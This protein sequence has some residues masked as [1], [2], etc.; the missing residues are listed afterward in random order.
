MAAMTRLP[1]GGE[2]IAAALSAAKPFMP[3]LPADHPIWSILVRIAS[4]AAWRHRMHS[5]SSATPLPRAEFERG[6]AVI[7]NALAGL[8]KW[9]VLRPGAKLRLNRLLRELLRA[10]VPYDRAS[11]IQDRFADLVDVLEDALPHW[12]AQAAPGY[13]SELD[14]L[15]EVRA[16]TIEFI[17]ERLDAELRAFDIDVIRTSRRGSRFHGLV[18]LLT[19]LAGVEALG[20]DARIR[21]AV[22]DASIDRYLREL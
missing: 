16:A 2:A 11:I 8:R 17:A 12:R 19:E 14:T 20:V 15:R 5:E 7:A 21:A 18:S 3:A 10:G 9:L 4:A 6:G 22:P 13:A 1:G